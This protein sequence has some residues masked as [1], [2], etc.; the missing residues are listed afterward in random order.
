MFLFDVP[1]DS[2][3]SGRCPNM[4]DGRSVKPFAEE[5]S[6]DGRVEYILTFDHENHHFGNVGETDLHRQDLPPFGRKPFSVGLNCMK[7]SLRRA[8]AASG[9]SF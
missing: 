6:L 1:I 3:L 5:E 4:L 7:N 9:D 2:D 8:S